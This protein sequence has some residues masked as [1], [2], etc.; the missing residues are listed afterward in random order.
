[1]KSKSKY[2]INYHMVFLALWILSI[3]AVA[4]TSCVAVREDGFAA[5]AEGWGLDVE[6]A[7]DGVSIVI[8]APEGTELPEAEVVTMTDPVTGRDLYLIKAVNNSD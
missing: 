1:V 8:V 3:L 7:G 6:R 5:S 2:Q 4:L